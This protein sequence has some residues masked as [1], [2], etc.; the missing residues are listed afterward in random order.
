MPITYAKN[1]K[2]RLQNQNTCESF[3]SFCTFVQYVFVEFINANNH[4]YRIGLVLNYASCLLTLHKIFKTNQ[5]E[6]ATYLICKINQESDISSVFNTEKLVFFL[7]ARNRIAEFLLLLSYFLNV[8]TI[9]NY[10]FIAT[11][12]TSNILTRICN[13]DYAL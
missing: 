3:R 6:D 9:L 8:I 13:P 12:N 11:E 2:N 5:M 4:R 10:N 1:L 7:F